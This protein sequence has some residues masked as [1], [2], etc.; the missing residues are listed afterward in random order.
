M[1]CFVDA[2]FAVRSVY[3]RVGS[4]LVWG[5][6]GVARQLVL[7]SAYPPC[8]TSAR[9]AADPSTRGCAV[10]VS[11]LHGTRRRVA[12]CSNCVSVQVVC[13]CHG[14]FAFALH[15]ACV[16]IVMTMMLMTPLNPPSSQ[17]RRERR[18]ASSNTNTT[19]CALMAG[20]AWH[21]L[22]RWD[23]D[24]TAGRLKTLGCRRGKWRNAFP[25]NGAMSPILHQHQ[26]A[27]QPDQQL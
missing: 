20:T 24:G 26:Q 2:N 3:E 25:P 14:R 4:T 11:W 7:G 16:G 9:T 21:T 1:F 22:R 17:L 15:G 18:R 10:V 8:M 6:V 5:G 19:L 13:A 12:S 23:D 27:L